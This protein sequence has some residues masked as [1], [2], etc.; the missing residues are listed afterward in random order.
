MNF[1]LDILADVSFL[2]DI[3]VNTRVVRL[4]RA[5][6]A[7]ALAALKLAFVALTRRI[8]KMAR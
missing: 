1:I 7:L 4:S 3:L 5:S 2:T 6:F 8:T